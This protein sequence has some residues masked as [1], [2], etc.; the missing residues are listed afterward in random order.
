M[1]TD[2]SGATAS[3]AE[4]P[5]APETPASASASSSRPRRRLLTAPT[6]SHKGRFALVYGL[7]AAAIAAAAVGV[8]L[9]TT[10]GNDKGSGGAAGSDSEW[11]AWK[12]DGGGLGA[13]QQ[14]ANYVG[15]EYKSES[16]QQLMTI[17][18]QSARFPTVLTD[19]NG[20]VGVSTVPLAGIVVHSK[21]GNEAAPVNGHNSTMYNLVC[22]AKK[23]C[24]TAPG[25]ATLARSLLF[26]R[27][28]LELALYTFKYIPS[29]D[30][31]L[32]LLRS[33]SSKEPEVFYFRRSDLESQLSVP[34]RNTLGKV[35][36]D[37]QLSRRE[38]LTV[39]RVVTPHAFKF[40]GQVER[41]ITGDFVLF[42]S[43]AGL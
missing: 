32:F 18:A 21:N 37:D 9:V 35:P 13:A 28:V 31:V 17:L 11:S 10:G 29:F 14:I 39:S 27:E 42:L 34:V 3:D 38:R 8:V 12:P 36:K 2:L 25:E 4:Q 19:A 15:K 7:L 23:A 26:R 41:F 22:A 43:P 33:D 20:N 24:K 1:A 40:P 5:A 16:G 30:S 6:G